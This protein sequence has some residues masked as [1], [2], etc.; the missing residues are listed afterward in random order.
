MIN[1]EK[2]QEM[3]LGKNFIIYENHERHYEHI[4]YNFKNGGI[5]NIKTVI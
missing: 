5:K 1:D 4:Y 2:Y 3:T